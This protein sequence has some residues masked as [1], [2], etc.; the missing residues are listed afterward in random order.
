[1]SSCSFSSPSVTPGSGTASSTVTISTAPHSAAMSQPAPLHH[2]RL[3]Y[4][5]FFAGFLPLG[6]VLLSGKR[7]RRKSA[8]SFVVV[9][10]LASLCFQTG[11]SGGGSS[12]TGGS[13]GTPAGTYTIQVTGTAGSLS[14]NATVSLTVQ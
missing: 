12:G 1:M 5:A 4:A 2:S 6:V 7:G 3:S 14:H 11:C 8:L 9:M 10:G 13:G